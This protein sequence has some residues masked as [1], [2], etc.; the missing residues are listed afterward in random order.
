MS[1]RKMY[2]KALLYIVRRIRL[3]SRGSE[4]LAGLSMSRTLPQLVESKDL[5]G[6]RTTRSAMPHSE[7]YQGLLVVRQTSCVQW[8]SE[9]ATQPR[10]K[11][12]FIFR[13]SGARG[14]KTSCGGIVSLLPI[15]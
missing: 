3:H 14:S 7:M 8:S 6:S 12:T 2:N 4:L 13:Q 15:C 5:I 9:A 10:A 11:D 1:V